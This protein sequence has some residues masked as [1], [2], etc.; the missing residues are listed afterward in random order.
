MP[1][2]D[3]VIKELELRGMEY[4]VDVTLTSGVVLPLITEGFAILEK[5][6][7][8]K[9]QR[10]KAEGFRVRAIPEGRLTD[11]EITAFVDSIDWKSPGFEEEI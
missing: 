6:D 10:I 2:F 11:D 4:R 3:R 7:Y 8:R 5:P 9:E 1:K